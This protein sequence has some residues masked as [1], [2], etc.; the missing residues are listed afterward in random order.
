MDFEFTEEQREFQKHISRYVDERVIPVA[1]S[2]DDTEDFPRDIVKELGGL[3]YL[4]IKYP[5]E[6][7]GSGLDNPNVFHC[8]FCEELARGSLGVASVL[9]MHTSTATH[10]VYE[11]GTEALRQEY[12][13]P[14]LAG[15]KI[16]AFGLTEPGAGSDAAAIR[17]RAVRTSGGW[18]LNGTKIFI[19]NGTVADFVTIAAKTDP[20]KGVHGISLFL[21]DTRTPGFSVGRRLEKFSNKCSDTAEL[22]LEDVE[23]GEDRLL[24]EENKGF[25]NVYLSLAIDRVM[26]AALALGVSRAAYQAALRYSKEREQFGRPIGK[27]QAV[28]F[29]LV[30]MLAKL[31]TAELHTYYAAWAADH[32]K[33]PV[34]DAAMA[35]LVASEAASDICR[36]AVSIFGGYGLMKEF[37]VQRYLRDSFFPL[38]AGGTND[39]MKLVIARQ[40]GL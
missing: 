4:G 38:V 7:G 36:M 11:W 40:S 24:G 15:D 27:F 33:N 5:Q 29:R 35:K 10:T 12:L 31:K 3:G 26:T 6:Y 25:T 13:V 28:E 32:G 1:E 34:A 37:A 14:A 20:E 18:R 23:V 39:I 30:D 21:V 8:I 22:V 16:A 19:S 17:T 2:L 9:G